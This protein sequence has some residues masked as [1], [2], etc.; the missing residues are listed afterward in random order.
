[1]SSIKESS[2][3]LNYGWSYGET[4]WNSGM[5]ENIVLI[6]FHANKQI[7]GVLSTPPMTN[8]NNGDAYIVGSSPTGTWVGN[9]AKVAIY[10][11]GSWLF[12]TP[13]TGVSVYNK[14]NGCWYEYNNGWSLKSEAEESPYIKVKDFDFSTG[15]T[16]IDSRQLL[17][18]PTNQ[19]YYQWSGV[20]PK[21]VPAGSTPAT[22]GGVGAGAWVDRTDLTLR[23]EIRETVFQNMKRSY[24]E[25]GLNLVDGSFELG[26]ETTGL[27]DVLLCEADGK[28]YSWHLNEAKTVATG[29]APTNIGTDWIDQS[30]TTL[31]SKIN[32]HLLRYSD[33]NSLSEI[34]NFITES[35]MSSVEIL[36]DKP[37][38][39]S[40]NNEHLCTL[41]DM[42]YL[43]VTN[44]VVSD[45]TTYTDDFDICRIFD[46][47]NIK[48]VDID[49]IATST[50]NDVNGDKQGL[51]VVRLNGCDVFE[52]KGST[53]GCYQ[54]H[55]LTNVKV[56]KNHSVNSGTRYPCHLYNGNGVVDIKMKNT[57]CRRDFFIINGVSGGT[58]DIDSTD[59]GNASLVKHYADATYTSPYSSNLKIKF[60]HRSTGLYNSVRPARWS[61]ILFDTSIDSTATGI[62]TGS[63]FKNIE[64][65]YDVVGDKFG[66]II[67]FRKLIDDS[68]GDVTGRGYTLENITIKGHIELNSASTAYFFNYNGGD[69]WQA[70]DRVRNVKLADLRI[71]G[72]AA[73][74][75]N[76][77]QLKLAIDTSSPLRLVNVNAVSAVITDITTDYTDY[78]IAESVLFST[79]TTLKADK[80]NLATLKSSGKV[81]KAT[82]SNTVQIATVENYRA[83]CGVRINMRAYSGT[84]DATQI[85]V[86]NFNGV[87]K[88]AS[89]TPGS[90]LGAYESKYS[91]GTAVTPALT[92]GTNG[93]V[94]IS[95]PEWNALQAYV[96][97]EMEIQYNQY[98][99]NAQCST[100]RG[101]VSK[102]YSILSV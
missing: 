100:I 87:I 62:V 34:Q 7:K 71:S 40:T 26:G 1:M 2:L 74:V 86:G 72:S 102:R 52:I 68:T 57:G 21:V 75:F 38:N 46:L 43:K 41:S 79:H 10:D 91:Q 35:S 76:P 80:N 20:F 16:I 73:P 66:S 24:A 89:T 5:D 29:S 14:A 30:G 82:S 8:V 13:S 48:H 32:L 69:N 28:A 85:A 11:R 18:Y 98:S 95:L 12:A 17:F 31:V 50:L 47:Q 58:I 94:Y 88:F 55:E 39:L 19:T 42:D 78:V 65:D 60:K 53:I 81:I 49:V 22:T 56:I 9:Y 27:N 51:C 61:P 54:L 96:S 101:L 15:Y 36:F 3:G 6:G 97:F 67:A 93:E 44:L 4:G 37:V 99:T 23:D 63:T 25:A 92:L 64:V 84:T 90:W 70:T 77:N 59:Q 45:T 33:F 83:I